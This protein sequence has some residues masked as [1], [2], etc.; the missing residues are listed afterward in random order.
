LTGDIYYVGFSTN[1]EDDIKKQFNGRGC[2]WT[3]LYRPIKVLKVV[4][5]L[6]RQAQIN[7]TLIAMKDLGWENV[8]GYRWLD[9]FIDMPPELDID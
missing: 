5:S 2:E 8:R 3:K 4:K 1:I 7:M 9:L 6:N